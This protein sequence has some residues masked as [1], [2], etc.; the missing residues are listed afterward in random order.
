MRL[1]YYGSKGL[2]PYRF[3]SPVSGLS[4]PGTGILPSVGYPPL[5]PLVQ[6]AVYDFYSALG[7]A[8]RF[9]YYFIVKQETII[10]DI[11]AAY[12]IFVLLRRAG[13][14]S[15]GERAFAFWMFCPFVI[16][17][18]A[19]WGMFDQLVL[20]FLLGALL[21][22]QKTVRS[23]L[24]ETVGILLK[25]IP[26]IFLPVLALS[27]DGAGKKITYTLI[28]IALTVG[29][30]LLPYA[31]FPNWNYSALVGT[32]T[33][34][35]HKVGNSVNYWV[36]PY[37]LSN[38]SLYQLST[39]ALSLAGYLWIPALAISYL[40][41][42]RL[43]KRVRVNFES[44]VLCLM[45]TT[46]VLFLSRTQINEQYVVYFVGIGLLDVYST[47][48]SR[49]K[50][51]HGVWISASIFLFAN[52]TFLVRFLAPVSVY[53]SQLDSSL[54]GGLSGDVRLSIMLVAG[55]SFTLF[56]IAYLRSI[57]RQVFGIA[58]PV[59][60]QEGRTLESG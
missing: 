57:H 55:V 50:L 59:V 43:L 17:I 23:S 45:I 44:V 58:T 26:V 48:R 31:L 18:S 51:F 19:V 24:L 35:V 25:G 41:C 12:L 28:S 16:V 6:A 22:S 32:G 10:P 46:L 34:I 1:G 47:G 5:W 42:Y 36:V 29:F 9:L 37:V 14:A 60:Q 53:Y 56:C 11:V 30:S 52:N 38:L 13:R 33:D 39:Q 54:T 8:N 7:V 15:E 2:D 4:I 40:Y 27:Q 21:V 49:M 20:V 3:T